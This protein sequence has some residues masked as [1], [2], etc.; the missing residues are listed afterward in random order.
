MMACRASFF[1]LPTVASPVSL[2]SLVW[3]PSF[4]GWR[5]F[6]PRLAPALYHILVTYSGKVQAL[7]PGYDLLCF[8]AD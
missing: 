4:R 6:K 5:V 1:W 7:N 2:V 8:I 3:G